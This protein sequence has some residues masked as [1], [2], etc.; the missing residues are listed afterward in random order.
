MFQAVFDF[1]I[2]WSCVWFSN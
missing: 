2:V 1:S